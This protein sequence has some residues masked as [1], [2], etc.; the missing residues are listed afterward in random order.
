ML[1]GYLFIRFQSNTEPLYSE[2]SSVDNKKFIYK[3]IG[4]SG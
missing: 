2:H 4:A 3:L 1:V